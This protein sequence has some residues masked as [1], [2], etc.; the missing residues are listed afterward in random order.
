MAFK[1]KYQSVYTL[2]LANAGRDTV[3]A[4]GTPALLSG[5]AS[6]A[7]GSGSLSYHWSLL[8]VPA[9]S[10]FTLGD[11]VSMEVE[12]VP[13]ISG[14]YRF[15]LTVSDS[16][17]TSEPDEVT[18]RGSLP[19]VAVAGSDTAVSVNEMYVRRDGSGSY[20][21]DGDELTFAWRLIS[22]P[23]ES[24]QVIYETESHEVILKSDVP[25]VYLLELTVS[26]GTS[27]S[28]PDT[29]MVT[30]L[31]DGTGAEVQ[32]DRPSIRIYP[33]PAR[34]RAYLS[35]PA[36]TRLR[37]IGVMDVNGRM[38]GIIR[39]PFPLQGPF[40]LELDS[41]RQNG[42]VLIFRITG[43]GFTETQRLVFAPRVP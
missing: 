4:V 2:P 28:A 13:D 19:P 35:I 20:D 33:N 11:S 43:E 36:G 16:T 34:D 1:L 40:S 31:E 8:S 41:Y 24:E 21:P 23:P 6:T 3:V 14:M 32:P 17:G 26:D 27:F 30:V 18:V 37:S 22:S 38:L 42:S 39:G 7:P 10:Q 9:G 15:R 25:G 29:V 5:A 12:V